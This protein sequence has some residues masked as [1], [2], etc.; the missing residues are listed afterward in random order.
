MRK[1]LKKDKMESV[2]HMLINTSIGTSA[3]RNQGNGIAGVIREKLKND[4]L[5]DEFFKYLKSKNKVDFK[6]Y[7]DQLTN[8]IAGL[9]GI[10]KNEKKAGTVKWGTARKCINLLLR[11]IVY[12]GFFWDKYK[13]KRT[14]FDSGGLMEKLELPLDSYAINGIKA[15][16]KKL[17]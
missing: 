17:T 13:L 10:S 7:L 16:C 6:N 11:T 8:Q 9:R 15:D 4:V 2:L 5:L 12:N 1:E 3:V 14:H